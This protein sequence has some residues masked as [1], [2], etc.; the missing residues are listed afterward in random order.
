MAEPE[1]ICKNCKFWQNPAET[2]SSATGECHRYAPRP[3]GAGY[4]GQ[5]YSSYRA[6]TWPYT[7]EGE[8]CGEFEWKAGVREVKVF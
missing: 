6:A 8:W 3:R 7:E 2:P 1:K 5:A 4:K